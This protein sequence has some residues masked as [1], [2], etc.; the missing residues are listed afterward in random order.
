MTE[1][2]GLTLLPSPIGTDRLIIRRGVSPYELELSSLALKDATSGYYGLGVASNAAKARLHV[3]ATAADNIPVLGAA[4]GHSYF[5]GLDPA[6]GL[7]VGV[8]AGTGGTWLQG[9]R[10]DGGTAPYS[11]TLQ[12][13]GGAVI[14]G[15]PTEWTGGAA[16]LA[17][18]SGT[19]SR[20]ISGYNTGTSGSSFIARVDNAA[21]QLHSF[22]F[23]AVTQVGSITT[24]GTSTSYATSSDY[25][26]KVIVGPVQ[27]A[28][29]RL[30]QLNAINF[31]WKSNG[32]VTDGFL[33][34]EFGEVIPGAATGTKDGMREVDV[35]LQAARVSDVLGPDGHPM[36]IPA[37][38][39]KRMV[40]DYQGIDQ[41]KAVPL[42]V[43]AL[44]E[45]I[46]RMEALEAAAGAVI[47]GG[48]IQD[49]HV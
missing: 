19:G 41:A 16:K 9:Q 35:V 31:A 18:Q 30:K 26:L 24:N 48:G 49:N 14:I 36:L 11:I 21:T 7:C 25:R 8:N 17:A 6:Y 38:T 22:F 2:V 28:I 39:E 10:T 44:Q 29:E 45:V 46:A 1:W 34:H 20:T 5:T 27:N 40:E 43:A 32:E 42:L 23:G 47:W 4:K 15:S 37:V 3:A 13:A 33:A 12:E